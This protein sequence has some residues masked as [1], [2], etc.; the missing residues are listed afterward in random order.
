MPTLQI[1]HSIR[2]F[3][4]WKAAFD[5]DPAG[6]ERSGVRRYRILRPVDDPQYVIIE[7]D[8]DSQVEAETLLAAMQKIW[9]R[10]DG[11]LIMNPRTRIV[12]LVESV[13]Y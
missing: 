9:T 12:D 13:E 5:S 11:T 4:G 6:R 7:L 3:D 8:F 2:D 10:V 1:E